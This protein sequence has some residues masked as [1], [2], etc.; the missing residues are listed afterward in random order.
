MFWLPPGGCGNGLDAPAWAEIADLLDEEVVLVIPELTAAHIP[1]YLAPPH[2]RSGSADPTV[3]RRRLWVDSTQYHRT[4][5][6]LMRVLAQFGHDMSPRPPP[7]T[8]ST[9]HVSGPPGDTGEPLT[10]T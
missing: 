1:A 8:T 4:E 5:D 9:R 6:V 10:S 3:L 7:A 2:Q